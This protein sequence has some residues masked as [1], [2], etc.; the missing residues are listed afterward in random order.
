M[1]NE[2]IHQIEEQ[3]DL[4]Y[5]ETCLKEAILAEAPVEIEVPLNEDG[6]FIN[7]VHFNE[8]L[9]ETEIELK[10]TVLEDL[11]D[12][13]LEGTPTTEWKIKVA[14]G[15][16]DGAPGKSPGHVVEKNA[17]TGEEMVFTYDAPEHGPLHFAVLT[18]GA[19]NGDL[20]SLKQIKIKLA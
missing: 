12:D 19:V 3:P 17:T 2:K 6:E 13:W 18:I 7:A 15:P 1:S 14:M 4:L 8:H 11:L 10:V 9:L 20:N 5:L 16:D